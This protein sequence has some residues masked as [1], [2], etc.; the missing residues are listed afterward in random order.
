MEVFDIAK[1]IIVAVIFVPLLLFIILF[2]PGWCWCGAM[3][4]VSGFAAFE[5]LRAAGEGKLR[6]P[7]LWA[8]L[9]SAVL[10]PVGQW[11]GWGLVST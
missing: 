9:I 3:V 10:I 8:A 4:I 7:M 5:L 1:R 6:G 2:L 11:A